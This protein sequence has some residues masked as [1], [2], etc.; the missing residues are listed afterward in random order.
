MKNF[1]LFNS[2]SPRCPMQSRRYGYSKSS[3]SSSPSANTRKPGKK[4]RKHHPG[5]LAI[6]TEG[7]SAF[8]NL[9]ENDYN[10]IL[11]STASA[12][13]PIL[14]IWQLLCAAGVQRLKSIT[15]LN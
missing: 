5:F 3:N 13:K 15:V 1:Y 8:S 11:H 6:Y 14:K 7:Y 10:F 4:P 9:L 12:D 2:F